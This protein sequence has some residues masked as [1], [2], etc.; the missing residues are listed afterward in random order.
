M[1]AH[2]D[3][4]PL[5]KLF[6]ALVEQAFCVEVGIGDPKLTDYL[7]S[8][9]L[10]FIHMDRLYRL[11]DAQGRRI[12]NIAEMLVALEADGG[13]SRPMREY[14]FHRYIGDFALFWTGV[15]PEG[16]RRRSSSPNPDHLIDYVGR[17]KRSYEIASTLCDEDSEP[18]GSLFRRLSADFEVCAHGLGL[19]R[20][21]WQN[22]NF[23]GWPGHGDL[24]Y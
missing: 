15:F 16:L 1:R 7:V 24:L 3:Q 13:G 21:N 18:S 19:V 11:R 8:M 2:F 14:D 4:L 9:L 20:Q 17:G 10:E 23:Q 6:S 5:K 22:R 12:E